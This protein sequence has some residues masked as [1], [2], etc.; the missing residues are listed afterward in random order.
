M[1]KKL[2]IAIAA[3][4]V[5]AGPAFADASLSAGNIKAT[6]GD[7]GTFLPGSPMLEWMGTEF[8][9]WGTPAAYFVFN[10]GTDHTS[11]WTG[12][13]AFAGSVT[14]GGGATSLTTTSS[15]GAWTF[16]QLMFVATPDKLS[17]ILNITNNT[18]TAAHGQYSVGFDPDQDIP[19]GGSFST[20]NN[21]IVS[22]GNDS[23]VSALGVIGGK[24]VTLRNNT[25]ADAT[26][27]RSWI[28]SD[29]CTIVTPSTI[30]GGAAQPTGYNNG[31]FSINLGYDL[32][33]IGAG[34]TV[35]IGYSYIFAAVPEPGTYALMLAGLGA[36]GF[37]AKRRKMM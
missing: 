7:N 36:V 13:S 37:I 18:A 32:G 33:M 23:A 21:I 31:D 2:S 22:S 14:T 15:F 12:T 3:A 4:A 6:V 9:N 10:D 5:M 1:F 27:I 8:I 29:C 30:M 24:M 34:E 28:G 19:Y 16:S 26:T 17:V 11:D 35:A 20:N 25:S